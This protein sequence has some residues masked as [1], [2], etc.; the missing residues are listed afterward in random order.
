[1][2]KAEQWCI[3]SSQVRE[4]EATYEVTENTYVGK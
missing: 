3:S 2:D 1:M 4:D